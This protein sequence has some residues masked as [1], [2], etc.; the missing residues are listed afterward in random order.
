[1]SSGMSPIRP[2][3]SIYPPLFLAVSAEEKAANSSEYAPY[4]ADLKRTLYGDIIS[5]VNFEEHPY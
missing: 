4:T 3:A 2:Q 1:M 5:E